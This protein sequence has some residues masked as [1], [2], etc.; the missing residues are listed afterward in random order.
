MEA[1]LTNNG[2]QLSKDLLNVQRA[3][4]AK[5]HSTGCGDRDKA[6]NC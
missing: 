4:K 6:E 2:R 1:F 5:G 3:A